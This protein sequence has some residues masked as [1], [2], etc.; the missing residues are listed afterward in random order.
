MGETTQEERNLAKGGWACGDT[1]RRLANDADRLTALER[2][3]IVREDWMPEWA[4]HWVKDGVCY[5][6]GPDQ[7]DL[8]RSDDL[9]PNLKGPIT[10]PVVS[11]RENNG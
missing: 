2:A 7:R 6:E 3:V 10:L 11:L 9:R 5:F 1:V 8:E 4:T